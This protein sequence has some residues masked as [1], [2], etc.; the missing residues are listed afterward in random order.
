[1]ERLKKEVVEARLFGRQ[2]G[3]IV[4]TDETIKKLMAILNNQ[5]PKKVDGAGG[6]AMTILNQELM[7]EIA[8]SFGMIGPD[9]L[10]KVQSAYKPLLRGISIR[11]ANFLGR[12]LAGKKVTP[13]EEVKYIL[14]H[15]FFKEI[16]WRY[17]FNRVR[18]IEKLI[19][20]MYLIIL[21]ST[22]NDHP[23]AAETAQIIQSVIPFNVDNLNLYLDE[24]HRFLFFK[25]VK[26]SI[27]RTNRFSSMEK[28][29]F[30]HFLYDV[31]TNNNKDLS[32]LLGVSPT[33]IY[34]IRGKIHE[35]LEE[36][37]EI[38]PTT[39]TSIASY[40]EKNLSSRNFIDFINCNE[41]V[42]FNERFYTYFFNLNSK[43]SGVAM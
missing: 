18:E 32:N 43:K 29:V 39:G 33:F 21:E 34:Q 10:Q 36:L 13:G 7:N 2:H 16:S 41:A 42:C 15:K 30:R 24:D 40:V 28:I 35:V 31:K 9:Q 26:D 4:P 11:S 37:A 27:E 6:M 1:M 38:T 19:A 14:H 12:I 5:S 25:F 23:V 3:L 22:S 8:C 20:K 17:G